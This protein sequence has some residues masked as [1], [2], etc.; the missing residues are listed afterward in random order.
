MRKYN[1]TEERW[2]RLGNKQEA[3]EMRRGNSGDLL[4]YN[5]NTKHYK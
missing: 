1:P 5:M 3:V 2:A 4:M